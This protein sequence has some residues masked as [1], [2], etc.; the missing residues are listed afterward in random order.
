MKPERIAFALY[1]LG[2]ILAI[3][4][5]AKLPAEGQRWPD[6][7]PL[8]AAGAVL[9]GLGLVWWRAGLKAEAQQ[10]RSAGR[11]APELLALLVQCRDMGRA[12]EARFDDLDD[13]ALRDRID[14][15]LDATLVPFVEDRF[16]LVETFGMKTGAEIILKASAAERN[17]NRVWS[18]AADAHPSEA[19]VSLQTAVAA[20]DEL[21]GEIQPLAE[22]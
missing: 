2:I 4:G 22:G 3:V 15:L 20:M 10:G 13:D 8:F 18:A 7:W 16:V 1:V 9:G 17:F 12:I 19:L 6:T 21:V 11:S 14:E 5:A